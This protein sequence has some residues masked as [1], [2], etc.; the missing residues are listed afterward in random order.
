MRELLRRLKPIE[1][2]FK[3]LVFQLTS[4][5]LRLRPRSGPIDPST[6]REVLIF[7][8]E[9]LGDTMVSFPLIDLLRDSFP[10]WRVSILTS[11]RSF[12]LVNG[13]PRF[14]RVYV[15]RKSLWRDIAELRK[16]RQRQFDCIIDLICGDSVTTLI[17]ARLAAPMGIRFG[18]QKNE[19]ASFYHYSVFQPTDQRMEHTIDISLHLAEGFGI[20]GTYKEGSGRPFVSERADTRAELF[21]APLRHGGNRLIGYNL[22]AGSPGRIWPHE[23]AKELLT[24]LVKS[25]PS[26]GII[27]IATASERAAAENLAK[28]VGPAAS[29]VPER[30]SIC[31]ACAIVRRLDLLITPDTSLVHAARSFDVP[32]VGLYPDDTKNNRMWYPYR[33]RSGVVVS[34]HPGNIHDI[35]VDEVYERTCLLLADC[36]AGERVRR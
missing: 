21:V 24:S 31:E 3:Q 22:S 28:A 29:L 20:A 9:R 26:L 17:L 35:P 33:Q 16:I 8:P 19:F 32:V 15:Y 6:I 12:S 14:D 36:P 34:S 23:K 11:P 18:Q 25:D 13:D 7:R 2:A 4:P 5:L 30:L 27:L 10:H 1:L